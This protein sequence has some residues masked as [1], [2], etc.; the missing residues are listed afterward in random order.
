MAAVSVVNPQEEPRL[1]KDVKRLSIKPLGMVVL[2]KTSL[3]SPRNKQGLVSVFQEEGSNQKRMRSCVK[4]TKRLVWN[5]GELSV[6]SF[7]RYAV[8]T[9][10]CT[11]RALAVRKI[12]QP[13]REKRFDMTV[14]HIDKTLDLNW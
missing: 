13:N 8:R 5:C 10:K 12:I 6:D 4:V 11:P 7:R 14:A 9:L 2:P 3:G 1:E